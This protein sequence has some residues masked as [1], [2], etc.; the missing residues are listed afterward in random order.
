M[1]AQRIVPML[2]TAFVAVVGIVVILTL[3]K[4]RGAL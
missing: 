4:E 2:L 1:H 3:L